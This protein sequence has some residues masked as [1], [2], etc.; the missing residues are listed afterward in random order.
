M[1]KLSKKMFGSQLG[2]PQTPPMAV[3]QASPNHASA[4]QLDAVG[5]GIALSKMSGEKVRLAAVEAINNM[6]FSVTLSDPDVLDCVLI[7]CSAGFE[8]LTGYCR[9]EVLGQNCW[10]LNTGAQLE[11][12]MREAMHAAVES[13]DE[14]IGVVPNVRK[15]GA[16]FLNL[17]RLTSVFLLGKRYVVGIQADVSSTN[18]TADHPAHVTELLQVSSSIFAACLD[19]WVG[20]YGRHQ[21]LNSEMLKADFPRQYS[22]LQHQF[23]VIKFGG[24]VPLHRCSG[25][26]TGS[27]PGPPK[28]GFPSTAGKSGVRDPVQGPGPIT[29][30]RGAVEPSPVRSLDEHPCSNDVTDLPN[31]GYF[32]VTE[33]QTTNGSDWVTEAVETA[34]PSQVKSVG[35]IGHPDSCGS[36]CIFHFFRA[37][38]KAG[39]DCR[40][41]HEYHP[42][43]SPKKN[44]RVMRRLAGKIGDSVETAE[45]PA[46]DTLQLGRGSQQTS[47]IEEQ[48]C[49]D[50]PEL[51][52][53]YEPFAAE[54]SISPLPGCSSST[55]VFIKHSETV[56]FSYS[57]R[58]P[59]AGETLALTLL[60][61]Q[62]VQLPVSMEINSQ[63]QEV[64]PPDLIFIVDPPL[65]P[66]LSLD[67]HSGTIFGTPTCLSAMCFH[68]IT[69][70]LLL[71]STVEKA[72]MKTKLTVLDFRHLDVCW[73][74]LDDRDPGGELSLKLTLRKQKH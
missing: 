51:G 52:P 57:G 38:C 21:L 31:F 56:R 44:R 72:S 40:F 71:G 20:D 54:P 55:E 70:S 33:R 46:T 16:T 10:F 68:T 67:R 41:C 47:S 36:E 19:A 53:M 29:G 61:D 34:D 18:V 12:A 15:D 14:F 60:V 69:V 7:G 11:M 24:G 45:A 2:P 27:G 22:E 37:G 65:P 73:G 23:V 32:T 39:Y 64:L 3:N 26:H 59:A 8:A 63:R 25:F 74:F 17:L 1:Q 43:R 9:S 6:S 62:Q 30:Q 42:R 50:T 48:V 28:N 66:G 4:G 49:P 58:W 5:L 13:G 35:S